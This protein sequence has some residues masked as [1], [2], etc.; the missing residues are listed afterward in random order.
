MRRAVLVVALAT[1]APRAVHAE[2]LLRSEQIPD[3]AR[4]LAEK[5]RAYHEAGDYT[6]AIAAFKEAYVLAPSPGLLF[7]LAQA[8]RL[9]GN[10][11]DAAWMYHRY[12]DTNPPGD[13]RAIAENHLA[14]VEKCGHGLLRIAIVPQPVE[15]KLP[16]PTIV[17]EPQV[18]TSRTP[19]ALAPSNTEQ[20]VG[21]TLGVGGGMMLAGAAWFAYEAWDA[22][23]QVSDLYRQGGNGARV[24]QLQRQGDTSTMYAEWL[25]AGG[26]LAA[27]AGVALYLDGRATAEAQRVAVSPTSGGA[28][29][30]VSWKF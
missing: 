24:A 14:S 21:L 8:Y 23:N 12:L 28:R 2:E 3:K 9:A 10:C 5:G 6:H 17:A 27:A 1:A 22:S 16:E 18:T 7:N 29:F 26:A 11:D 13:R 20:K 25:G 30:S 19:I 15:S 4:A